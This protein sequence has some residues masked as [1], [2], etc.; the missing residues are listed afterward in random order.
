MSAT[1]TTLSANRIEFCKW[2]H[3]SG[4]TVTDTHFPRS[5]LRG[6]AKMHGMAWAPAWIVKD[7]SRVSSRG[8][9]H[10]PEL[11]IYINSLSTPAATS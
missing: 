2:L 9:Y 5:Y 7:K 4:H 6:I 10:I 11:A 8:M 1:I 3:E